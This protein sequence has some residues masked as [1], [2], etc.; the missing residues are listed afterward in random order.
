M[1]GGPQEVL[2]TALVAVSGLPRY[3]EAEHGGF[4]SQKCSGLSQHMFRDVKPF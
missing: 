4:G 2:V 3:R 1:Q